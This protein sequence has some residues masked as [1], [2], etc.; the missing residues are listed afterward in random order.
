MIKMMMEGRHS[1]H[2]SLKITKIIIGQE[3]HC[4]VQPLNNSELP[5]CIQIY[6]IIALFFR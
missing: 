6:Y 2:Y 5:F 4:I 3:P 1:E